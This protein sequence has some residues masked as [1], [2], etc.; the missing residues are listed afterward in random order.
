MSSGAPSAGSAPVDDRLVAL[1]RRRVDLCSQTGDRLMADLETL[2]VEIGAQMVDDLKT[3]GVGSMDVAI[4]ATRLDDVLRVI[5]AAQVEQDGEP[6]TMDAAKQE[7][8]HSLRRLAGMA[9]TCASAA[10]I[11][12]ADVAL[13]QKALKTALEAKYT[14][15]AEWWSVSVEQPAAQTILTALHDA[16]VV[17]ISEMARR[18]SD[19][20]GIPI[21][22]AASQARQQAA[23]FDRWVSAAIAKDADPDGTLLMWALVGPVDGIE[24][25]FCRHL[26]DVYLPVGLVM[27]L[28]NGTGGPHPIFDCGGPNCRHDWQQAPEAFWEMGHRKR[29]TMADVLAANVAAARGK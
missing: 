21:R 7:L 10:G 23:H 14:D 16:R 6:L 4:D 3:R 13:D 20:L 1:V 8:F 17:P 28:D 26:T 19:Q 22:Q 9:E 11:D 24:R 5:D 12:G 2:A 27:K 25:P 18:I 15:V 29:G